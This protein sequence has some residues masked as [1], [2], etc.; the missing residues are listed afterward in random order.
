M[1][2]RRVVVTGMGVVSPLGNTLEDTWSGV[3][4]GASGVVPI[5]SFDVSAFSTR[6]AATVKSFDPSPYMPAKEARKMDTFLQYGLIAG[7]QAIQD[8]G[9]EISEELGPRMGTCIGSGMG[10]IMAIENNSLLIAEKGPRRVS[11]FF[12][13]GAIINMVAGNLSI[14]FGLKGPNL[15]VT[16]ACTTGTHAIGLGARTIQHGDADVM[17]CGGAEMVTT[18]VGLGGFCAARALSTR[19]DDPQAASR[20]WDKDRDGFVLGEG[21]AVLVLEEYECAKARGAKI[22]AEVAGFGMSGDAFHMTSPPE[23]GAGAARSMENALRDSG[24]NPSDIQYINAHGTSTTLGDKAEILAVHEVF[25]GATDTLAVSSTKS[26][27]GHLL[28]AAGAIEAVF[29]VLSLRD[30]VAPPTTNLF[31]PDE[32]CAGINLVPHEAQSIGVNAVLSNSFGF[33]GTNGSLI[34][35]RV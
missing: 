29:S 9:L 10:G 3:L 11:P 35:K 8:S 17:V 25:A 30:Q 15:S 7:I 24:M 14:K 4:Q 31:S 20:P 16:T 26:M 19:N 33:G 6:F 32:A 1:S 13:P 34:F 21:S 12:V 22:Y 23:D 27:T 2:H 18:P 5:D 28:G